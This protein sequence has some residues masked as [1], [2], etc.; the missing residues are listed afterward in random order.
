MGISTPGLA[1]FLLPVLAMPTLVVP[2]RAQDAQQAARAKNFDFEAAEASPGPVPGWGGGGEGYEQAIDKAEPHGGKKCARLRRS[3]AAG[4]PGFGTLVQSTAAEP[5]RLK[6][7]RLSAFVRTR[8]VDGWFGLWMRVDGKDGKDGALAFDNMQSRAVRGTTPW[9]RYEV[10]L[11]VPDA[12]SDIV[13]GALLSGGGSAWVDD[14]AFET[15]GPE[16]AVTASA[17]RGG[18]D[19]APGL[20]EMRGAYTLTPGSQRSRRNAKMLLPMPLCYREQVPLAY[21]LVVEPADAVRRVR[22]YEDR[23]GN[24]VAEIEFGKFDKGDVKVEWQAVVLCGARAATAPERAPFPASW[25]EEARPWARATKY[26]Q[27][28]DEEIRA[29]AARIRGERGD[30]MAVIGATLDET[31]KI[32]AAQTGRCRELGAV[33]ALER[34]GSCTSCANL[35]AALLRANGIPARILAGYP[36]W[37]GPLQTHYNVEAFVPEHGWYLIESTLLQA[38]WPPFQQLQVAIVPPEYED[39]G[40]IRHFTAGGVPYLSL[41]EYVDL[42]NRFVARGALDPNRSCDH[43]AAQLAKFP[44]DAAA[45]DWRRALDLG[46]ERWTAWVETSPAVEGVGVL[47]SPRAIEDVRSAA[48]PRDVIARLGQKQ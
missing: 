5:Y 2:L 20:F 26:A 22:V 6:R 37:S 31:R 18:A 48:D 39:L 32:F 30:V 10:V 4:G 38:P 35:V 16:I 13:F 19:A 42:D 7:V 3:K 24:F 9:T 43:A 40:V 25:P 1:V 17:D 21:R 36:V 27:A 44:A 12:A 45:G 34:Q 23:P 46:R 11:D 47:A 41:T 29:I 15:V 8:E 28:D 14:V 33:E